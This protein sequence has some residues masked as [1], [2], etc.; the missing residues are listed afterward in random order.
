MKNGERWTI[1][2][3]VPMLTRPAPAGYEAGGDAFVNGKRVEPY[4]LPPKPPAP[5]YD[6]GD[7]VVPLLTQLVRIVDAPANVPPLLGPAGPFLTRPAPP[8]PT[9]DAS[10]PVASINGQTV[11]AADLAADLDLAARY[12][13]TPPPCGRPSHATRAPGT[14]CVHFWPCGCAVEPEGVESNGTLEGSPRDVLVWGHGAD[15]DGWTLDEAMSAWRA[16]LAEQQAFHDRFVEAHGRA[17][18]MSGYVETARREMAE[19]KRARETAYAHGKAAANDRQGALATALGRRGKVAWTPV[20]RVV[21]VALAASAP[22][23]SVLVK[24]G[25]R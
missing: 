22:D 2:N 8:G 9:I 17:P 20:E 6:D 14:T 16:D 18:D 23:G 7:A 13:A 1:I 4:T 25:G 24:I 10:E 12:L 5:D 19:R 15:A 3:Y 11:T 21:G